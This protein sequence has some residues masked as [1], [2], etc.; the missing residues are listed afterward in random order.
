MNGQP[1][2]ILKVIDQWIQKADHDLINAEHTLQLKDNCPYDTIC[3]HVQQSVEK[4]IKALLIQL[5]I[6]EFLGKFGRMVRY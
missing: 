2:E 4:Y 3:F 6:V 1:E 5:E